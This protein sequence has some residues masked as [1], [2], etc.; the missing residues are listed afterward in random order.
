MRCPNE[1]S[2]QA[3]IDGELN[4]IEMKEI[5]SH[6]LQCERC[7]KFYEDLKLTDKFV[8]EKMNNYSKGYRNNESVIKS[9]SV[10]DNIKKKG[11]YSFMKK[12][13]KVIVAA[14][15]GFVLT[16]CIAVT[17]IRAAIGNAVSIFRANDIKSI[18]VTLDDMK[19]LQKNME[20]HT[21]N[22]EIDNI[23][24]VTQ[25]GGEQKTVTMEEAKK[26][27]DFNIL[28][29]ESIKNINNVSL[30]KKTKIDFTLNVE[31]I[32][33]LVKSLGSKKL[34]PKELDG[35]TFSLTLP[36]S[37]NFEYN[38]ASSSKYVRIS[39]GKI[40]EITGPSEENI[41]EVV[42]VLSE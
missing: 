2:I 25:E 15:L 18:N 32:N 1:G 13:K 7:R 3:Y 14:S 39:E 21:A 28:V 8:F 23:G 10:Q 19:K 40:P 29:P 38:D 9:I 35:K 42:S 34:F 41:N 11:E 33:Q 6:L 24:K 36:T 17:P 4:E 5:K 12:Y 27:V 37:L 20:S 16:S 31:N 22:I 30:E 26:E